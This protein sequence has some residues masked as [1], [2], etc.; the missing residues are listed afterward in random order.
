MKTEVHIESSIE[1]LSTHCF[2]RCGK[3]S[4][5]VIL[6]P[7]ISR[8]TMGDDQSQLQD[9]KRVANDLVDEVMIT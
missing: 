8:L 1:R 3:I 2:V 9:L 5:F 4:I 6:G 7:A